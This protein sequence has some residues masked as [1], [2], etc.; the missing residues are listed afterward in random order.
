[1][2]A[3]LDYQEWSLFDG[4][5]KIFPIR[6][7]F[8]ACGISFDTGWLTESHRGVQRPARQ[9]VWTICQRFYPQSDLILREM[10]SI[11]LLT[12]RRVGLIVQ[13]P[14]ANDFF[15]YFSS[16]SGGSSPS[17]C[18]HSLVCYGTLHLQVHIHFPTTS[19]VKMHLH[20]ILLHLNAAQ[21]ALFTGGVVHQS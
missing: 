12:R 18:N 8:V 17:G 13:F 15:S 16:S 1:M 9:T 3:G 20:L 5:T 19:R 6:V 10:Y 4:S 14:F 21:L 2:P 7:S 11:K